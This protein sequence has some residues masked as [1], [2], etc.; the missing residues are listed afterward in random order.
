[1]QVALCAIWITGAYPLWCAWQANRRTSLVH[2]LGWA[3]AAWVAWSAV[4]CLASI[5]PASSVM[6]PCYLALCLTGCAGVAVLGARRPGVTAWNF[7][8]LAL[9][10]VNLLPLA[11]DLLRGRSL[12][13]DTFRRVCLAVTLTIG[14][15]NYLPTR[16]A[17]TMCFLAMGA[18]LE[19][20][21]LA[22]LQESDHGVSGTL[23]AGWLS[24]ALAPW[25]G[26]LTS[27]QR[28]SSSSVPD[29]LW[30]QFRDR[31]G[32]IWGLRLRDQFNRA[33]VHAGWPMFLGWQGLR[34]L[35]TVAQR[36]PPEDAK[37]IELLRALMKRFGAQ[38]GRQTLSEGPSTP[39]GSE[40]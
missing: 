21:G 30:R 13:V 1:M 36:Q 23:Q 33:A 28:L 39:L 3:I 7:V 14:I 10:A 26:Y 27:R 37:V 12:H 32:A 17:L 40:R 6:V 11:E 34:T 18:A 16:L 5:G 29:R 15:L 38:E 25:A 20:A 24:L 22:S 9:L 4:I 19:L 35:P 2:A 31:F 8:V